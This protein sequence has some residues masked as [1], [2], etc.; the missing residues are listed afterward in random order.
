MLSSHQKY[1][2]LVSGFRLLMCKTYLIFKIRWKHN[3][4][5]TLGWSVKTLLHGHREVASSRL[6]PFVSNCHCNMGNCCRFVF[7]NTIYR[8]LGPFSVKFLRKPRAQ[9]REMETPSRISMICT[10]IDNVVVPVH[11]AA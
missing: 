2:F 3:L 11:L 1:F 10:I 9:E 7:Y 5:K 6:W 8:F 4:K